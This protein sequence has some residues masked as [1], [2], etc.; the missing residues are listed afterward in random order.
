MNNFDP[1]HLVL[2][3]IG[4]AI[5]VAAVVVVVRVIVRR[6]RRDRSA[7]EEDHRSRP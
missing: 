1:V 6:L 3:L 4:L 7:A 2:I 5:V